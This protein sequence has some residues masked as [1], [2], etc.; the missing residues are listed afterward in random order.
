MPR[1]RITNLRPFATKNRFVAVL[2]HV[3]SYQGRYAGRLA[4]ET[5]I[6]RDTLRRILMGKREPEHLSALSVWQAICRATGRDIPLN[7]LIVSADEEFPTKYPC[8]L[9][10]CRCYPPWAHDKN[11]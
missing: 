1:K 7:E 3:D 10:N 9:F 5:G 8:D 11:N 4:K 6:K 2:A